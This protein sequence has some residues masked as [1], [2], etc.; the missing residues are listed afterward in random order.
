MTEQQQQL[1]QHVL[2]TKQEMD[3][4]EHIQ[5]IWSEFQTNTARFLSRLQDSQEFTDVTL[6]CEDDEALSA[7]RIVL[8]AGSS[9]LASLLQRA[10]G[11]PHPLL[12]LRGVRRPE[13]EAVLAFLYRGEVR[14]SEDMV[15]SFLAQARDLGVRGLG[16]GEKVESLVNV[17]PVNLMIDNTTETDIDLS[18]QQINEEM[19]TPIEATLNFSSKKRKSPS[20]FLKDPLKEKVLHRNEKTNLNSFRTKFMNLKKKISSIQLENGSKPDFLL[21]IKN[22]LQ[23][24][25]VNNAS[26]TAGKYM[27]FCGGPIR[28]ILLEKGIK[29]DQTMIYLLANNYDFS[30]ENK[31]K[32]EHFN[33]NALNMGS[34][35]SE[36]KTITKVDKAHVN[37]F[38]V[39]FLTLKKK[40]SAFQFEHGC[41]ADFLLMMRNNVQSQKVSNPSLT[42]G[43]YMVFCDGAIKRALFEEGIKFERIMMYMMANSVDNTEETIH[44]I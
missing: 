42:A 5:M 20:E 27:L 26:P 4:T 11:H 3:P 36:D 38:K 15:D 21:M 24:Q 9:V 1:S 41:Q 34:D 10:G 32:S 31:E 18:A 19:E 16:G 6:V 17:D 25:K 30:E 37:N 13:L 14:V 12:L 35:E 28:Q 39:K 7:H 2:I 44:N 23:S 22:N 43:K 29:F 40:V 33:D 8:S